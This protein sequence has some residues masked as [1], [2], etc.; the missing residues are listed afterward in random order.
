MDTLIPKVICY[1]TPDYEGQAKELQQSGHAFD[2]PVHAI[3]VPATGYLQYLSMKPRR[4]QSQIESLEDGASLL[5]LDADNQFVDRPDWSE[6]ENVDFGAHILKN[7][8]PMPSAVFARNAPECRQLVDRWVYLVESVLPERYLEEHSLARAMSESPSKG[9]KTNM[10][11]WCCSTL[12]QKH[13]IGVQPIVVHDFT[14][15]RARL[16]RR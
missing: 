13:F 6:F 10:P 7:G 9:L 15:T 1:F 3:P 11:R 4:I 5:Y 14:W 2:V 8:F 12:L 16:N